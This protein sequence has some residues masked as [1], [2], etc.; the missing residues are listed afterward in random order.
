[1]NIALITVD[2]LRADHMGCY[3]YERAT[4]PHIDDFAERSIVYENAF[5]HACA[6]RPS[7]PAI[8]TLT[9]GLLYGGYEGLSS[10]QTVVAD[11]LITAGYR[12]GGFHSN[13]YLR[14]GFGYSEGFDMFY[15]SQSD[16]TVMERLRQYVKDNIDG[17]LFELLKWSYEKTEQNVG[18]DV[19][20]FYTPADALTD[21]AIE[22]T[23]GG[24]KEF[25]WV[26]YMDPHHPYI[27]PEEFQIFGETIGKRDAMKLRQYI[28]DREKEVTPEIRRKLV[29][30]YDSE[31]RYTDH[32][33]GRLLSHLD[34]QWDEWVCILTSDHGEEFGEHGSMGH[35]NRFYDEHMHIPLILHG[36]GPGREDH[37]VGHTDV[38][39][40]ILKMAGVDSPHTYRG[41][42]MRVGDRDA[43]VG[44]WAPDPST[45]TDGTV[46]V[47]RDTRWKIIRSPTGMQVYDIQSDPK[48]RTDLS[49]TVSS[50]ETALDEFDDLIRETNAGTQTVAI[51]AAAE[52]RLERLGYTQ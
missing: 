9:E 45:P 5:S 11:P 32:Y 6:T 40:T 48:E 20:S 18:V 50:A 2:S 22:W 19:G 16:S 37:M 38:P 24:D 52:E 33:I 21:R 4:T 26:H 35:E 28:T 49:E 34:I 23:S 29:Q 36:Q 47:Y 51:S 41:N 13:P 3:G 14:Q 25:L 12:T 43:V 27:P 39:Q 31:I 46:T 7:F 17:R 10:P 15:D 44:G 8:L 1:M 42:D 30:L